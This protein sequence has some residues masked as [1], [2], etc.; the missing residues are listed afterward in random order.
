MSIGFYSV[1]EAQEHSGR[2]EFELRSLAK[3]GKLSVIEEDGTTWFNAAEVDS[4]GGPETAPPLVLEDITDTPA[5]A[6]AAK[7]ASP[8][9]PAP[10]GQ[11]AQT[12]A[13]PKKPD[14]TEVKIAL[15]PEDEA[16]QPDGMS[17][18]RRFGEGGITAGKASHDTSHLR[19]ALVESAEVATRC[20]TFHAKLNDAS[21]SYLDNLINEWVD[22][23]PDVGIKFATS[24]IGV[25]EGKHAEPHL[26]VTVFY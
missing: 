25:V 26:I 4:L 3:S 12:A 14:I 9:A 24:S 20:R 16:P 19:R 23:N 18:I 17:K 11:P 6:P 7:S 1:Q 13:A 2:S 15:E 21:L 10:A 8:G 5:P 22:S